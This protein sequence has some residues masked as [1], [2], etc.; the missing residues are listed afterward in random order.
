[1]VATLV[2]YSVLLAWQVPAMAL[3]RALARDLAGQ[4]TILCTPSG[5]KA[6]ALDADGSPGEGSHLPDA[7]KDCPIC[8]GVAGA[9]TPLVSAAP[10]VQASA[11]WHDV[12]FASRQDSIEGRHALIRRGHDPPILS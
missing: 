6:V 12:E 7:A 8:Q 1:M 4:T 2:F 11:L 3:A 10:D 5:P 9:V